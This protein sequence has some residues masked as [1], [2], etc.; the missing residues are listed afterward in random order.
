M[1]R[2]QGLTTRIILSLLAATLLHTLSYAQTPEQLRQL[3]QLTPAQRAAIL[4]ALADQQTQTLPVSVPPVISPR[5]V[6]VPPFESTEATE[7][8][9]IPGC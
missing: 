2:P 7:G 1:G 6:V 3:E 9:G 8:Q 4:E 5:P